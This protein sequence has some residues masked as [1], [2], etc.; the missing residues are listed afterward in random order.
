[1]NEFYRFFVMKLRFI[2]TSRDRIIMVPIGMTHNL[3][4]W[5]IVF[6]YIHNINRRDLINLL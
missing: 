2:E 3:N 6:I 1:M 5:I 4:Y